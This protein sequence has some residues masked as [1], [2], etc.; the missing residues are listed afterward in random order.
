M[1]RQITSSNASPSS[2]ADTV[3]STID[4]P[5]A[6]LAAGISGAIM[7]WLV[8]PSTMAMPVPPS[9]ALATSGSSMVSRR[10][11]NGAWERSRATRVPTWPMNAGGA[12]GW[13]ARPKAT[14]MASAPV[15]PKGAAT[16]G[17]VCDVVAVEVAGAQ[18]RHRPRRRQRGLVPEPDGA[19]AEQHVD[20]DAA[21]AEGGDVGASVAVEVAGHGAV[22]ARSWPEP[23]VKVQTRNR[24][25]R[26]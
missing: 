5:P 21:A 26:K 10:P 23:I 22:H 18:P 19:G 11:G 15:T 4:R 7:R 3:A 8:E 17:Q 16:S 14:W 24:Q 9:R 6:D 1:S 25:L 13:L 20:G 12:G 2:D